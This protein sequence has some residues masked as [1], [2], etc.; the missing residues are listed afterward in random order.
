VQ[1]V[2]LARDI[3]SLLLVHSVANLVAMADAATNPAAAALLER[4]RKVNTL[5]LVARH[6]EPLALPLGFGDARVIENAVDARQFAPAAKDPALLRA[7]DIRDQDVV[8]A[9]VSNLKALKRPLD[10]VESAALALPTQPNLLYVVVGEGPLREATETA[11]RARGLMPRFRFV[12]WVDRE[13]VL[14]YL[15]LADLVAMPSESEARA[16]LYLEA[17]ACGRVLLASDIPAAREVIADGETGVLFRKGDIRDLAAKT[18][19][20]AG[21]PRRRA[22]IGSM[23]R[24][25]AE[26]RSV[27]ALLDAYEAALWDLAR[28]S[29]RGGGALTPA[30]S[31]LSAAP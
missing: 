3:P 26:N 5:V 9:H 29:G 28:R 1:G 7:L 12:N 14:A 22:R 23:A 27:D 13:R 16:M 6:L 30:A 10:L 4:Y 31:A 20:L 24:Q 17:Q 11:V 25:A 15:N 21:D 8:V 2:A 19:L 18:L